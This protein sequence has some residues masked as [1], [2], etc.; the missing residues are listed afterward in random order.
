MLWEVSFFLYFK[1]VPHPNI[2]DSENI[3]YRMYKIRNPLLKLRYD[4]PSLGLSHI[5]RDS[6]ID[7]QS[8]RYGISVGLIGHTAVIRI[9]L[10]RTLIVHQEETMVTITG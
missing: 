9:D 4:T 6:H 2:R 10:E 5:T 1:K 7:A 3:Y 8:N